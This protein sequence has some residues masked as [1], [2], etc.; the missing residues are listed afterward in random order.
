MAEGD[1]N[2]YEHRNVEKPLTNCDTF[3]S[4]LKCV[5]GTGVLA[6]PLAIAYTGMIGGAV[7]TTITT[8]VLTYGMHLLIHCMVEA[9]RQ[10]Q[11]GYATFPEAMAHA[12]SQGPG[13]F[14]YMAR[15]SGWF[16]DGV[17]GF[18]Q[19][20]IGV[21]YIVFV[22]YNWKQLLDHLW[23]PIDLHILI[24]VVGCMLL[25]LFLIRHLKYLVPFN[26]I[27]NICMYLGFM[28]IS[29]YLVRGL[30]EIT[31]RR[32]FGDPLLLPLF[33]GIVLFA[34]TAVGVMLSIE[35]NMANPGAYLGCCGILNRGI[36]FV[37]VTNVA[38]GMIGYWRYGDSLGASVTLNVPQ[39]E[40]LSQFSKFAI[41]L[42]VFLTYPL[43]G[44]VTIDIIMNHYV[45]KD[46]E[47]KNPHMIEYAV[48]FSFV[49][50]NTLNALAFPNLGPLLALVGAFTI[51]ILNL[52]FPAIIEICLLYA[53]TYG[54]GKWKLWKDIALIIIGAAIL[55]TGTYTAILDIIR[56]YGG[57]SSKRLED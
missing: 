9:A 10:K 53:S 32:M 49:V 6:M 34:V 33:F 24:V 30:P 15:C 36:I 18:S 42:A 31:D 21:V 52:I 44:Y 39:D 1:F 51:S 55:V 2:P 54:T 35:S 48:R 3:I 57:G 27:A 11:V 38:F 14:R 19:Y 20:C 40:F 28:A 5:I 4:L 45:L 47:V 8:I 41:S 23:T 46:R 17:L 56:E 16:V 7:L 26:I 12:F 22:A 43:A 50:L 29:Y 37:I 25:P 13:C